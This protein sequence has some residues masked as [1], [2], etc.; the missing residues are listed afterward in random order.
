MKNYIVTYAN[1]QGIDLDFHNI[2]PLLSS[3]EAEIK[4]DEIVEEGCI[5]VMLKLDDV[6]MK[7]IKHNFEE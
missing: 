6:G 2:N 1:E 4:Y 3:E 7:V 5:A